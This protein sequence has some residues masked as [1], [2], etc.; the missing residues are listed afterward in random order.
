MSERIL[1]VHN[2]YQQRGGEDVVV[3]AEAELLRQ[4]GHQV[5]LFLRHNSAIGNIG[6]AALIAQTLWSA[7][8]V[9]AFDAVVRAFKPDLVHVH[10]TFP[11]ISPSLYWAAAEAR[12]PV[13]QTLHNFRLLCPQAMFLRNG[14]ICEDCLGHPPWRSVIHRCYRNSVTQ[15]AVLATT[16]AMHRGLN[17]WHRKVTRYIALN[18]FCRNKFIEGG[19]PAE[20][21][22]VKPNFVDAGD[23]VRGD[24][25][26]F[27]FVGRLSVEKGVDVLARAASRLTDVHI[28]VVG[29]G[30]E[31]ATLRDVPGVELLGTLPGAQVREQMQQ[32]TALVFPSICYE[33]FGLVAVEAFASGT[34]VIASRIGTLPNLVEED[35]TGLLFS[36]GD[37]ADL[38]NKMRWAQLNPEQMA[39][40]GSTARACYET[41]YAA[42]RN[43]HELMAIYRDAIEEVKG[44]QQC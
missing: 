5:E 12:V 18:E 13:V 41:K 15:S 42:A 2:A 36:P 27:L 3:E 28:R 37:A 11:L 38:A 19:L 9:K 20:R 16:L 17:T 4:H 23:S 25:S 6:R 24:R 26:G 35:V 34:P 14:R 32:A 33:T 1:I 22:V 30:S 39:A 10:N 21:I 43:Y 44:K 8:T 7:P 29:A 31:H 40:M